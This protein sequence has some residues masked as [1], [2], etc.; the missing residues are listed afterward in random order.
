M[1][2]RLLLIVVWS[3]FKLTTGFELTTNVRPARRKLTPFIQRIPWHARSSTHLVPLR[4]KSQPPASGEDNNH[5]SQS[6]IAVLIAEYGL[7]FVTFH[8]LVFF[9]VWAA[10]FFILAS[11][12]AEE[13]EYVPAPS[14]VAP[15]GFPTS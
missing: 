5:P 12:L 1:H 7:V 13:V 15:Q 2:Q 6:T 3:F 11:G 14:K 9:V 10:F 8:Y 4:A